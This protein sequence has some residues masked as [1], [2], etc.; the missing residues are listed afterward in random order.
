MGNQGLAGID[1][2]SK[3]LLA[4]RVKDVPEVRVG[5]IE[6]TRPMLVEIQVLVVSSWRT[7]RRVATE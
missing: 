1:N 2:P 3:L 7:I 4:E 6:G 5:S